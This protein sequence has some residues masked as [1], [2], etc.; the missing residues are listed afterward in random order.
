[1]FA[2][3]PGVTP[4]IAAIVQPLHPFDGRSLADVQQEQQ[5]AALITSWGDKSCRTS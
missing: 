4:D 3:G 1:L 5:A 2:E